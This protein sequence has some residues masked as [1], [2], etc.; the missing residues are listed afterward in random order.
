MWSS[1]GKWQGTDSHASITVTP[2][3][4]SLFPD[5]MT[6]DG[7]ALI[8][9]ERVTPREFRLIW[10]EQGRGFDLKQVAGWLIRGVHVQA[11]T[12]EQARKKALTARKKATAAHLAARLKKKAIATIW[13]GLD[14]S[15][16]AGNCRPSTLAFYESLKTRYG[17]EVGG[18]R[19]DELLAIRDDFYT[20]RAVSA[21][22]ARM[23]GHRLAA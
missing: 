21:A 1:N 22:A 17:A 12:L 10:L 9:A 8:D 20:R 6:P 23:V 19:A 14:D 3:T 15:F 16:N 13:V 18:L 5:I 7:L 11:A 2:T 4:I